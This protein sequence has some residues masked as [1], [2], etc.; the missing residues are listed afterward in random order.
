[1]NSFPY[2]ELNGKY[3]VSYDFSKKNNHN[4]HLFHIPMS[5]P[6]ETI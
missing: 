3:K 1:M 2:T 5:F 4:L 6:Q